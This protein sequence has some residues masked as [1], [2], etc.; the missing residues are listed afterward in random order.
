MEVTEPLTAE[1][2]V[3]NEVNDAE[4]ESNNGGRGF[5]RSV[6]RIIW[7]KFKTRRINVKWFHQSKNKQARIISNS[8]YVMNHIYFPENWKDRWP[9]Y[10]RAMNSYQKEGKNKHDDAPDAT[11]GLAEKMT[12]N[13]RAS[14]SSISAW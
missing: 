11:T 9:E 13:T 3:N 14:I 1:M 7:E 12:N 8:T 5:A 10:Y 2:L 4:F 6:E